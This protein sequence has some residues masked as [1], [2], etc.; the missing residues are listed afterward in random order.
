MCV[1]RLIVASVQYSNAYCMKWKSDTVQYW[2]WSC[3][4][5]ESD[6]VGFCRLMIDEVMIICCCF[7]FCCCCFRS[8]RSSCSCRVIFCSFSK[9]ILPFAFFQ[10]II[11]GGAGAKIYCFFWGGASNTTGTVLLLYSS[12]DL[13]QKVFFCFIEVQVLEKLQFHY[14]ITSPSLYAQFILR[15]QTIHI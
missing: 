8:L 15:F 3:T 9:K 12:V 6:F 10:C 11:R 1:L 4:V 5:D 2:S 14:S 13:Q 7:V